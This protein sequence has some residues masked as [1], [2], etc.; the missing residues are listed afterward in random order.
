M[1][2]FEVGALT[3]PSKDLVHILLLNTNSSSYG[4]VKRVG[5]KNPF[6]C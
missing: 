2:K 3:Q 1:V 6:N 4:N 5:D